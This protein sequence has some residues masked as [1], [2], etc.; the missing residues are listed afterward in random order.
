MTKKGFSLVEILVIMGVLGIVIAA[1]VPAF[2]FFRRQSDLGNNAEKILNVLKLAQSRTLASEKTSAPE[3]PGRYGVYFDNSASPNSYVFFKGVD[4][5]SRDMAFDKTYTLPQELEIYN[6]DLLGGSNEVVFERLTGFTP[7]E[8]TV[9]LRLAAD[10]TKTKTI[11]IEGSGEVGFL[12]PEGPAAGRQTD[13]RH[14]HFNYTRL[15]DPI[16]ERI[17]L[18]FEGGVFKEIAIKDFIQ[19][20]GNFY[21]EG[22]VDVAG[23]PQIITIHTHRLNNPDTQ[24]CMHRDRR[25]NNKGLTISLSGDNS[26]P[27]VEYSADGLTF[28][29]QSIYV[30]FYEVQ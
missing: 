17:R 27:L 16:T 6:I 25:Y 19:A 24:W 12:A 18:D 29:S 10:P 3:D 4:F 20:D 23:S 21:W 26:G 15:I 28:S 5:A 13:S 14:I 11:Y 8:G 30:S 2:I 9:S 22:E 1:S 7:Q